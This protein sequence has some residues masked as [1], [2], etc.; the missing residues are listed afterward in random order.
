MPKISRFFIKFG[1]L[2][3]FIGVILFTLSEIPILQLNI[4]LLPIYWH[5]I[6]L[7][8][9]SQIIFGVSL[10]M[11]PKNKQ[12]IS[13]NGSRLS[14]ISFISLNLGLVFRFCSEPFLLNNR[15]LVFIPFIASIVLQV[16]GVF[17]F[18]L[19]IWPRL[20]TSPRKQT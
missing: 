15:E 13:K 12:T 20:S 3:L 2:Y 4:P 14:W 16:L 17:C 7:G 11:F 18:I 8:W 1:M 9:I 5:M 10:W 19:E 6:A